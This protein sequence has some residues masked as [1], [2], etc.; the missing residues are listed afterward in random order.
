MK[1][2]VFGDS[3]ARRDSD[4]G[5]IW[6][7][8]LREKY[9]HN[10]VCYGETGS[11]LLFSAKKILTSAREFDLVIWVTTQPGR[12]SLEWANGNYHFQ[13]GRGDFQENNVQHRFEIWRRWWTEVMDWDDEKIMSRALIE[14]VQN[15]CDNLLIVPGFPDPMDSEFSLFHIFQRE[16]ELLYGGDFSDR[17]YTEYADNR[18]GHLSQQSHEILAELLSH[19]LSAGTFTA[20]I[21]LFP[22]YLHPNFVAKNK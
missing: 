19:D 10:V 12:Q 1:I 11:S 9:N 4:P 16:V 6:W 15:R 22:R 20:D 7:S 8:L 5:T 13:I 18:V 2:G 17:F 14:M 3:Y 21:D